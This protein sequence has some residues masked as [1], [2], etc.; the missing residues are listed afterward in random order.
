MPFHHT[1]NVL[2][3]PCLRLRVAVR[4]DDAEVL[5]SIIAA[6][7]VDVVELKGSGAAHPFV[8]ATD[9]TARLLQA[10]SDQSLPEAVRVGRTIGDKDLFDRNWLP[11]GSRRASAPALAEEVRRRELEP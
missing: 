6:V 4:T 8:E 9:L 3:A 10:E 7:A 11:D 5:Q 2:S 1:P